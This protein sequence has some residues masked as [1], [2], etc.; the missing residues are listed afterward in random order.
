MNAAARTARQ[1]LR[2]R[3]ANNRARSRARRQVATSTTAPMSAHLLARGLDA[4]LA[5]RFAGAVTRKAAT[6]TGAAAAAVATVVKKLSQRL[7]RARRAFEVKLFTAAA[8]TAV[9]AVYRPG[10]DKAARAA[11]AALAAA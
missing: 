9:L 1:T 7:G 5:A 11:F 2:T 10:K 4:D 6:V 3:A 8:V